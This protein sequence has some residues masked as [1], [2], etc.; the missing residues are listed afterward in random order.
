MMN[1]RSQKLNIEK[2][3]SRISTILPDYLKTSMLA[4][5][6][7]CETAQ[8]I[9]LRAQQ[10]MKGFDIEIQEKRRRLSCIMNG[11]GFTST[12]GNRLRL[13]TPQNAQPGM[14]MGQDNR[15]E[16]VGANVGNQFRSI[17]AECWESKREGKCGYKA[18]HECREYRRFR[19]SLNNVVSALAEGTVQS[20]YLGEGMQLSSDSVVYMLKEEEAVIQLQAEEFDLKALQS[21]H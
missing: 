13:T 9:W 5:V 12:D 1:S 8:E 4:A 11:K 16:I 19:C 18:V 6:D 10:M 15:C 14:N 21:D 7:S 20:E 17:L 3:I 2:Q